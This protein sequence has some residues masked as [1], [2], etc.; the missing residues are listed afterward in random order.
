MYIYMYMAIG[1][2]HVTSKGEHVHV[3]MYLCLT[4]CLYL[5]IYNLYLS[6]FHPSSSSWR[7]GGYF[8]NRRHRPRRRKR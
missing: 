2:L 7:R 1:K 3:V 6:S 8:R 5:S 4:I